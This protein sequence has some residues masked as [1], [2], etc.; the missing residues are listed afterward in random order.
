VVE[1]ERVAERVIDVL[2]RDRTETFVPGW[3]RIAPLAQA[4][5]PGLLARLLARGG[6]RRMRSEADE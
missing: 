4:L 5:A 1:P 6:Y 3:Y 2:V